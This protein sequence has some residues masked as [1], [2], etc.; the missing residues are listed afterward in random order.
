MYL[1]IAELQ[2]QDAARRAGE[3][4]PPLPPL[5]TGAVACAAPFRCATAAGR[6]PLQE[7]YAAACFGPGVYPSMSL[8]SSD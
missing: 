1:T 5:L 3:P 8:F 7:P 2:A 6:A 4:P